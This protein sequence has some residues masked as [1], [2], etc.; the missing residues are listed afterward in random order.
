M[1][2]K[3]CGF[4]GRSIGAMAKHYRKKHPGAM[5]SKARRLSTPQNAS[6]SADKLKRLEKLLELLG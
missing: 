5:K 2:C 6:V 1:K 4:R 3:K